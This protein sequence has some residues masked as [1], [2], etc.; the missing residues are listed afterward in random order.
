MENAQTLIDAATAVKISYPLAIGLAGLGGG[1]GI[2]LTWFAGLTTMGRQPELM[3]KIM[4]YSILATVFI[5]TLTIY[6]IASGFFL[7]MF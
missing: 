5:E 2:G 1:I 6:A 4:I 3:G 7:K